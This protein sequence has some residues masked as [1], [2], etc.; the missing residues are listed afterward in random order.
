MSNT[1][2][3]PQFFNPLALWADVAVKT[4][5]MLVSSGSVIQI[6]TQRMAAAGMTPSAADIAEFTLMGQEKLDAANESNVA[7]ASELQNTHFVLFG[8][9]LQHW[10]HSLNALFAL[11]FS[12][13]PAQAF[14]RHGKFV[15]A[16][17]LSA[18][19]NSDLSAA[20]ARVAQQAL[21]PI[22]AKATSNARRLASVAA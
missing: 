6:R 21:Q 19:T 5:E 13:T 7:M 11:A 4:S 2:S 10:F 14:E 1:L 20:P 9:A 18:A 16:A 15:D 3:S 12:M 17:T 8:R 22:H